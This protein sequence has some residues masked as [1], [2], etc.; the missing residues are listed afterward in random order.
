M[1]VD[2]SIV[3]SVDLLAVQ[4]YLLAYLEKCVN[5]CFLAIHS[6]YLLRSRVYLFKHIHVKCI[7]STSIVTFKPII[8]KLIK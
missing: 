4:L 2:F 3:A 8:F 1:V 5:N 6:L 7:L